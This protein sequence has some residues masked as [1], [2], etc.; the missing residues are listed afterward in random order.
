MT[1][2]DA[3]EVRLSAAEQRELLSVTRDEDAVAAVERII[4][5]READAEQRLER[6]CTLL[7]EWEGQTALNYVTTYLRAALDGKPVPPTGGEAR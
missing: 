7:A 4:A 1:Q 6:V 5:A 3:R 2:D